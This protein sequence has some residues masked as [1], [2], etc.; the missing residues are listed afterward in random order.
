MEI[1]GLSFDG[2]SL[3]A[4]DKIYTERRY[5][6]KMSITFLNHIITDYSR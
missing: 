2:S 6:K 4:I 3:W 5:R 1:A